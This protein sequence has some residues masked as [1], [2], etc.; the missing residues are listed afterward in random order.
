MWRA[1]IKVLLKPSILDPQGQAA[2]KVLAAMGYTEV[3]QVRVGKYLEV[4]FSAP[5]RTSAEAKIRE[6]C[7]RL[8]VNTV[9][10][11]YTFE[12]VEVAP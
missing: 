11:G 8:L 3:N 5:D 6:L 12:L 7:S 10:E 4:T 9:I 2:E 1:E